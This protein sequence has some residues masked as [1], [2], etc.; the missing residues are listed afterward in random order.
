M[1]E[2]K[3]NNLP[4]IESGIYLP[5]K[6][7]DNNELES[8][9]IIMPSGKL[10]SA[11]RIYEKIGVRRRHISDK[12]EDVS[13]MGEKAAARALAKSNSQINLVL[14]SSSHPTPFNI[15]QKI[16]HDLSLKAEDALDIHAACSGSAYMFAYLFQN[17]KRFLNKKI[18]MIA[19]EKFS[20]VIVDLRD[21]EA[22]T[23]DS[24]LGQTIFGDGASALSFILGKD[25]IIHYAINK[26]LVE[27][28]GKTDLIKMGMGN[29]SFIEPCIINPVASSLRHD[30]YPNGYF[31]QNGPKVFEV[32]HT[33]VPEIVKEI[34]DKAGFKPKDIKLVI[35]HPGSRRLVAALSE[36]LAPEFNVY[37][38]Y[39]DANM[40][41]TSLLYSLINA[42][43][44]G[45]INKGDRIVLAG[46]GA[47]S[48]NLFSSTVI[49]EFL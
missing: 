9:Q 3:Q 2:T 46:F 44:K 41:S 27:K 20:N 26:D 42:I 17:S 8:R 4:N 16:N 35:V 25:I 34:V 48:P 13:I 28:Q 33:Y 39:E 31:S 1:V 6:I 36:K 38:D 47:G 24:S 15:A 21:K 11:L 43:N 23:L 45:F 29:N 5:E 22:M 12:D 37:S 18:L 14:V 49:I 7:L 30:K 19:S 32:V 40:S 10:L